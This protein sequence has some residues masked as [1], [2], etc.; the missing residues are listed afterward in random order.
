M[1]N[2]QHLPISRLF[3]ARPVYCHAAL[4]GCR[5][6]AVVASNLV[7]QLSR[8]RHLSIGMAAPAGEVRQR[9]RQY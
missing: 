3:S 6:A 7:V 4:H 2:S 5:V 1:F 9:Q 8:I